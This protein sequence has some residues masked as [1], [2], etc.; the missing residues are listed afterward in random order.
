MESWR[1][2]VFHSCIIWRGC[3]RERNN[4]TVAA[5]KSQEVRG[6]FHYSMRYMRNGLARSKVGRCLPIRV[7]S[8]QSNQKCAVAPVIRSLVLSVRWRK[9]RGRLLFFG[10]N[11]LL[12]LVQTCFNQLSCLPNRGSVMRPY[13]HHNTV[14]F[15]FL[16]G[17]KAIR[18]T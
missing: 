16:A 7:L 9:F 3:I 8:L 6:N 12:Q 2:G 15:M 13:Y 4:S 17:T 10:S 11:H 14:L 18:S 5:F 1:R